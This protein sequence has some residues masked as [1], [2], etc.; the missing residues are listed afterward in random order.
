MLR[1]IALRGAS[2][3]WGMV[4][5]LGLLG[6]AACK[7]KMFFQ[8]FT[9]AQKK[10]LAVAQERYWDLATEPI[11]GFKH[12]FVTLKNGVRLHYV[13]NTRAG[14]T[15]NKNV[16]VF[17]HGFPDS[18][19]LWRNILS[20]EALEP[21][22]LIAVDLPGY[23][24]S[25]GL[26]KYGPNEVLE[27]M[28]GFIVS[29]R[30]QYLEEGG[31]LVMVTHDWGSIVGARLASEA[32]ELAD[33]WILTSAVMPGLFK[34]NALT[35]VASARQM[36]H[37]W[38]RAPF[39]LRLLKTA[40]S[41]LG[42]VISQIKRSYYIFTFS[43][44]APLA[45]LFATGGNFVFVRAVHNFAAGLRHRDG[46]PSRTLEGK[47]EAT[48]M[49]MTA[50]PGLAQFNATTADGLTYSDSV[51]ARIPDRGMGEKIRYYREGLFFRPW[52]KS[53]E[54]VVALS[55]IETNPTRSA[56]TGSGG[57]FDEGPK[58][59]LRAPTTVIMGKNDVAFELRLVLEG[60]GDYLVRG[61][62]VMVVGRSG[63][64]LPLELLGMKVVEEAVEWALE[65]EV[66]GLKERF[67]GLGEVEFLVEK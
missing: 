16:A 6:T 35:H 4:G 62:Q 60:A 49:A 34:A 66:G 59:A 56:S 48:F 46:K 10:E 23:G 39:N 7:D 14:K 12:A 61:S 63:H 65:G 37:T 5:L 43:L 58:G 32:K 47:D 19:L 57:L 11:P 25:D 27:A 54:T 24:G 41:T 2:F 31:K 13:V 15:K 21:F 1:Q 28:T 50:G 33:R 22:I 8:G 51:K 38:L 3:A 55:E 42:P 30:E 40:Y 26:P 17:V 18:Y 67:E 45:R 36:L 44:P 9:S 20:S 29:I 52:E 53:I 64:W